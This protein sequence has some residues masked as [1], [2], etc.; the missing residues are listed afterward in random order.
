VATFNAVVNNAGTVDVQSGILSL[1]RGGS[2][3]GL[4]DVSVATATLRFGG[5]GAHT[6]GA[7]AKING[8][9]LVNFTGVDVSIGGAGSSY[10]VTGTTQIVAGTI[11]FDTPDTARFTTFNQ[12]GGFVRGSA[13]LLV[14]GSA[15]WTGG[16]LDGPA[17]SGMLIP[18]AASLS[19]GG[20]AAKTWSGRS[21]LA[22]GPVSWVSSSLTM[23]NGAVLDIQPSNT[24]DVSST[25]Q[26]GGGSGTPPGIEI[27]DRATMKVS[28]AGSVAIGPTLFLNNAGTLDIQSGATLKMTGDF[29][30]LG[31]GVIMGGGTLD[32]AGSPKVTNGG[33]VRPGTSPG[34][35][36]VVGNWPQSAGT[37]LVI[38]V[39]GPP[40]APGTGFDQFNISGVVTTGNAQAGGALQLVGNGTFQ[41]VGDYTI[42]NYGARTGQ[43]FSV[44]TFNLPAPRSITY[45]TTALILTW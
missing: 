20:V 5:V 11:T 23:S 4:Y 29:N 27:R 25:G 10:D 8:A 13:S 22:F 15:S 1:E 26:W 37:T 6:L 19:I 45:T 44:S 28:T 2:S 32:I 12:L 24:F 7:G 3:S 9:G 16:T 36:S 39:L 30:N 33:T 14:R 18:N 17:G 40:S 38:D 31:T 43:T 35:L 42:M 34:I 21:I 41:P